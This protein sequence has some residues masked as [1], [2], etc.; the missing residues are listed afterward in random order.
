MALLSDLTGDHP[1]TIQQSYRDGFAKAYFS[2]LKSCGMLVDPDRLQGHDELLR[3]RTQLESDLQRDIGGLMSH[4][5]AFELRIR[6]AVFRNMRCPVI[7][8]GQDRNP[9]AQAQD[10][11]ANALSRRAHHV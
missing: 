4:A 3:W 10:L 1:T 9:S 8:L 6:L 7:G 11:A 2:H 5:L